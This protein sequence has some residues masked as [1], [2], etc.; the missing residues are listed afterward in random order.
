M[1]VVDTNVIA[2]LLIEG[3]RTADAQAL[4]AALPKPP[5]PNINAGDAAG[6]GK[7]LPAGLT[8]AALREQAVRLGVP[9]EHYKAQFLNGRS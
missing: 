4:I 5:P 2:Y 9:F 3:D 6:A 8:E 7:T 1:I